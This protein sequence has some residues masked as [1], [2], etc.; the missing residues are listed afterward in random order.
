M[1]AGAGDVGVA[2]ALAINVVN[3][4]TAARVSG[5]ADSS[6]TGANVDAATML[7]LDGRAVHAR[8]YQWPAR[9]CREE[10]PKPRIVDMPG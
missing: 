9:P 7:I 3:N 1:R 4:A 5:D 8:L 6:G 10:A 2:G